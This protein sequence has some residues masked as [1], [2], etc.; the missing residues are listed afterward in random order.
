MGMIALTSEVFARRG[1]ITQYLL[2]LK[3]KVYR[4]EALR[5]QNES[6]FFF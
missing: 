5:I 1:E 3:A 4:L 6:F 2:F